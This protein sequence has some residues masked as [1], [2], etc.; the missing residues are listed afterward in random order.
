MWEPELPALQSGDPLKYLLFLA[1]AGCS[2]DV[3]TSSMGDAS[4]MEGGDVSL[5]AD[6]DVSS[7]ASPDAGADASPLEDAD[8]SV[9]DTGVADAGACPNPYPMIG[10]SCMPLGLRACRSETNVWYCG[11]TWTS[12]ACTPQNPQCGTYPDGGLYCKGPVCP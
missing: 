1:L 8:A 5:G 12:S 4:S 9:K 2:A 7:E 11:G 6:G 3:F 10:A